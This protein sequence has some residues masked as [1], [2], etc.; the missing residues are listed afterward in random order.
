[1][2]LGESLHQVGI[3]L[4]KLPVVL[5]GRFGKNGHQPFLQEYIRTL[6]VGAAIGQCSSGKL[7]HQ[8]FHGIIFDQPRFGALNGFQEIVR[9]F[10]SAQVTDDLILFGKE[11]I[12]FLPMVVDQVE[13]NQTLV[14]QICP[15]KR[16]PWLKIRSFFL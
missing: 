4:C 5:F 10:G 6:H 9:G 13:A 7:F 12:E 1:M 15:V 8:F 14:N 3:L 16:L 2:V 11:H